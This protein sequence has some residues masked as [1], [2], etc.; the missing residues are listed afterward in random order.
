MVN[1]NTYPYFD[2]FD[3]AKGFHRILFKPGYAVQAREL[4]QI[5]SIL[6]NQIKEFGNNILTDGTVIFGCA[7][8]TNFNMPYIKILDTYSAPAGGTIDN[9]AMEDFE[10]LTL[11]GANQNVTA[12]VKK[13]L[14][15]NTG[16]D[17]K[18]FYLQYTSTGDDFTT[19]TF[20]ANEQVSVVETGEI[21]VVADGAAPVGN[22]SLFTVGDGIVYAKGNFVVHN[23]QTIVID[24]YTTT[25]TKQVGY[26]ISDSIVSSD[27]DVS[28]LDPAQGSFNYT[29]PGADRY[30]LETLLISYG[31][32]EAL[33]NEFYIL[34]DVA[35]GEI[36]RK[37]NTTQYG[38]LNKT[39]ARRT[40]DESG[41][42]T[43]RPFPLL[44]QEHLKTAT[45]GGRYT[46]AEGGDASQLAINVQPGKAY[47]RGFEHELFA[48]DYLAIDKGIA[49]ASKTN[50]VIST[51]Y[52]YYVTTSVLYGPWP[53]DSDSTVVLSGT[54]GMAGTARVREVEYE[55]SGVY[56]IYL[57]DVRV[58]AG[59]MSGLTTLTSGSY[60][61]TVTDPPTIGGAANTAAIFPSARS[62][63]STLY[64]SLYSFRKKFS[65]KTVTSGSVTVLLTGTED[66]PF[67]VTT[68]PNEIY[69]TRYGSPYE[70]LTW[71]S[72][73]ATGQSL[74]ISGISADVPVDIMVTARDTV[75]ANTKTLKTDQY[76]VFESH[77]GSA[78]YSLGYYDIKEI[79]EVWVGN[80][81]ATWPDGGGGSADYDAM[82]ANAS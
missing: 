37:Y 1:L 11:L 53:I 13:A 16:G 69:I 54:G 67:S 74:V 35:S 64:A 21:V 59:A 36:K 50:E 22:G 57:Y 49:T 40:Y 8:S 47:V 44:V 9:D 61:A 43:V 78:P 15:S 7:E 31:P 70:Q 10:G 51:H 4:T 82:V 55:S 62:D 23:S 14:G 80:A 17:P 71:T 81:A 26:V 38:E 34:F 5:Q 58:T 73:T 24:R 63:L 52:G 75:I 18:T 48:T 3:P 66:F 45:N 65:N 68:N 25:P 29:A 39:L 33:D 2:D 56:R 46:V 42:Y 32:A 41:D 30:H 72:A 6:Q 79:Q 27:D 76:V 20:A 77:P 28:L 19:T 60:S 12:V